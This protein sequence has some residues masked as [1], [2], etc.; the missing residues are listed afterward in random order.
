MHKQRAETITTLYKLFSCAC[1]GIV[2]LMPF[3]FPILINE[4][5]GE[6][7]PQVPILMYAM[8]MRVI[9]GLY[10]CIYIAMKN[11]K[12]VA[13]TSAAAAVI[14]IVVHLLLI[15]KIGLFAASISTF[16][17][18]GSM[19]VIRYIDVNRYVKMKISTPVL[20]SS[21]VLGIAL[22]ISYY[23]QNTAL[24]VIF[25]IIVCV[26]AV[27]MNWKFGLKCLA[28]AKELLLKFKNKKQQ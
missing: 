22:M 8:L 20:V 11:T 10:S 9:V 4:S 2:A 7:Y 27:A 18:F 1:L 5:Y 25:L 21:F 3:V 15:N 6:A 23:Q 26:Y 28:E 19:A 24:D 14:N 16:V 12:K 13:Y 17:A